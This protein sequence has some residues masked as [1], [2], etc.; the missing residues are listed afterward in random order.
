MPFHHALGDIDPL[1]SSLRPLFDSDRFADKRPPQ[2]ADWLAVRDESGRP[3][4]AFVDSR[5]HCPDERR[6]TIYMQPLGSFEAETAPPLAH[7]QA[8]AEA[9]FQMPVAI[10]APLDI[11]GAGLTERRHPRTGERQLL[12]TD[13][14][15]LLLDHLPEDAF[16]QVGISMID[17]YPEP[18]WNF[19]FGQA[20][21][22]NRVGVYSF[23]RYGAPDPA[24]T[25]ARSV[26]VMVHETMHMFGIKHC[27]YFECLM[28]GTNNLPEADR[29]PAFLCPI[30]L[31]KLMW[32]VGF[33]PRKRYR[34]LAEAYEAAGL[35]A[36]AKRARTLAAG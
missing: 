12:T 1:P 3:F 30:D 23:A 15:A 31:R 13:L 2:P 34:D 11:A 18:S 7:L 5:P 20:S 25:L 4:D 32:C 28:N 35:E 21:L 10:R 19:V 8:I 24:V 22:R 33:D 17:L 14:L 6:H 36:Y 29:R 16:C 26:K 9:F 27:P